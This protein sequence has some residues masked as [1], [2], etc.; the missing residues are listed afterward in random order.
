MGLTRPPPLNNVKK[1]DVLVREV[2]PNLGTF[3][4]ILTHKIRLFYFLAI[5][6]QDIWERVS[7]NV[8]MSYTCLFSPMKVS[9]R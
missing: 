6:E 1:I 4:T 9:A 5:Y 7:L 2:F 8:T 3:G